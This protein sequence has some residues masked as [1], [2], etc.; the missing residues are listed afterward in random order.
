MAYYNKKILPIKCNY[1]IY[2]KELFA[3]IYYLKA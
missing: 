3:I 2:N 1:Y